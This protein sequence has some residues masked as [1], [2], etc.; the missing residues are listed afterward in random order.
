MLTMSQNPGS[1][2]FHD[3]LPPNAQRPAYFQMLA[4]HINGPDAVTM[5]FKVFTEGMAPGHTHEIEFTQTEIDTLRAGGTLA[6]KAIK[7]DSTN[8]IHNYT[9]TCTAGT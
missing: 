3:H 7:P 1:N 2:E 9:I 8:E 6:S 5:S 4:A